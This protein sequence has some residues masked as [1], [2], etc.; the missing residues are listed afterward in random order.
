MARR[1]ENMT[2]QNLDL[3]IKGEIFKVPKKCVFYWTYVERLSFFDEL[4]E[5]DILYLDPP[6]KNK[7]VKHWG[8]LQKRRVYVVLEDIPGKL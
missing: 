2:D 4:A 6:W 7:S 8:R 5:F 1:V 3:E